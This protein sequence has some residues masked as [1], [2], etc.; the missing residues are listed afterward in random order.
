MFL[1]QQ[2]AKRLAMV[3]AA[4]VECIRDGTDCRVAAVL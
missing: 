4:A 3:A 2:R 1:Y